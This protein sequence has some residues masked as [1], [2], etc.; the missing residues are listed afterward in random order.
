MI[1]TNANPAQI[2]LYYAVDDYTNIVGKEEGILE[3][4][5][6]KIFNK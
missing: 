1:N 4:L 2:D 5:D 3:F 6:G